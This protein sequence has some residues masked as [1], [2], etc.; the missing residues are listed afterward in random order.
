MK[1]DL[2]VLD[3]D[4]TLVAADNIVPA[5]IARAVRNAEQAGLKIC[6]ATGRSYSETLP[7]WRQLKLAGPHLPLVVIGGALVSEPDTGRSLYHKPIAHDV[8]CRFGDIL[9]AAGY[10][11]MAI[12]DKWRHDVEYLMTETG[13]VED[14]Q[15]RW[16]SKMNVKVRRVSALSDVG[17]SLEVSGMP[18]ILRISTVVDPENAADLVERL[19]TETGDQ[20]EVHAIVAPNYGVMIVE[21]H[22]VGANKRTAVNYIAQ[23]SGTPLSRVAA[24]GDDINDIPILSA[25][26]LGVAM[27]DAPDS[28]CTEADMVAVDGLAAFIDRLARGEFDD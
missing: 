25:A 17:S 10:C 20:V 6:L 24:V 18:E 23:A 26:G 19:R 9:G 27:P 12:V 2:L 15:R 11:A 21:A 7:V 28:V 14:A 3:V 1:Y 4:G 8:A 13:D 5:D 16:F 22:A